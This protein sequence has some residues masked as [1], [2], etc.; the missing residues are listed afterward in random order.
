MAELRNGDR[1]RLS[2]EGR[3]AKGL[4]A[5]ARAGTVTGSGFT[6]AHTAHVVVLWDGLKRARLWPI[7]WLEP[8][9]NTG[10]SPLSCSVS[11][12]HRPDQGYR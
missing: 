10:A 4:I 2:A 3:K 1:V 9:P 12:D 8:L 5:G 6:G 7:E 11:L